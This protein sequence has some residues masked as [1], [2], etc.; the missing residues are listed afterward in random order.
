MTTAATL[1]PPRPPTG[2]LCRIGWHRPLHG[3]QPYFRD[4]V[5]GKMVFSAGCPCGKQW[6]TDSSAP[7]LGFKFEMHNVELPR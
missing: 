7:W 5:S 3:H 1:T 6:M 4:L 2:G